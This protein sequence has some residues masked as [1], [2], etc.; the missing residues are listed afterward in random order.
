MEMDTRLQVFGTGISTLHGRISAFRMDQRG[1]VDE[2][3]AELSALV[4]K[5]LDGRPELLLDELDR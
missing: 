2:Q 1:T 3:L 4:K 5:P